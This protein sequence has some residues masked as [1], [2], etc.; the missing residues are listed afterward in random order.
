VYD[1]KDAL[2]ANSNTFEGASRTH[3]WFNGRIL[4]TDTPLDNIGDK[5]AGRRQ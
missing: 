1:T 3:H 2:K 5:Y 4:V